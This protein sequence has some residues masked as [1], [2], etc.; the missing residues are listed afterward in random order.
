MLAQSYQTFWSLISAFIPAIPTAATIASC[1]DSI[2]FSSRETDR[3]RDFSI[4]VETFLR[5]V[6]LSPVLD[7]SGTSPLKRAY[8]EVDE[9][10]SNPRIEYRLSAV[11][12]TDNPAK[13]ETGKPGS[14][15]FDRSNLNKQVTG[16]G[17]FGIDDVLRNRLRRT[18]FGRTSL[19]SGDAP[20]AALIEKIHA[21]L[22]PGSGIPPW[23]G[24]K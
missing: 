14:E 12:I 4:H 9:N 3:R 15:P 17:Y 8:R 18:H 20:W 21:H 6:D 16:D 10:S 5:N 1:C 19:S 24:Q 11:T 23:H 13:V 2:G 22:A 7:R